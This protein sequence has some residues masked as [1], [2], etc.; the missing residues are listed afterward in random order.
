MSGA[1]IVIDPAPPPPPP[2]PTR[3]SRDAGVEGREPT[4]D[5]TW[6][7]FAP[8]TFSSTILLFHWTRA[9]LTFYDSDAFFFFFLH[10]CVRPEFFQFF[11]SVLEQEGHRTEPN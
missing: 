6:I 10:R 3:A 4:G 9:I 1:S 5:L 2:T 11:V 8:L 7:L